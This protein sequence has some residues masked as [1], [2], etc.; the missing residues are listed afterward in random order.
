MQ[1]AYWHDNT[2]APA[3][4]TLYKEMD[5]RIFRV[6]VETR[7]WDDLT[8]TTL[9]SIDYRMPPFDSIWAIMHYL[10]QKPATH[11]ILSVM[12]EPPAWVDV[13]QASP[14]HTER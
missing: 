1:G 12:V 3:L 13:S 6:I 14:E 8:A 9:S 2:R 7:A 5:A 10:R 4:D 11:V